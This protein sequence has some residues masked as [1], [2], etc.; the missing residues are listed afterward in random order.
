[1]LVSF[2]LLTVLGSI[3]GFVGISNINTIDE[4]ESYLYEN[5]TI[6]ISWMGEISTNFQRIRVNTRDIILAETLE[7]IEKYKNLIRDYRNS[8]DEQGKLFEERIL[9]QRMSEAWD[10]FKASRIDYG[11]DLDKLEE[12]AKENRDAEAFNLING[13]MRRTADAEMN[14]INQIMA[15]KVEDAKLERDANVESA[16]S[17]VL[18]M[19]VIIVIAFVLSI[20]LGFFISKQIASPLKQVL[21]RM[22]S[23][24]G[25]CITNLAKGTEQLANGDLNINILTGTKHLEINTKDEIGELAQNMNNVITNTQ[26]TVA[27]VDKAVKA[28]KETVNEINLIVDSAAKGDLKTRGNSSNFKGSFK[29]L[30]EGLNKTMEAVVAPIKEQS[31]VLETM[32]S[33]DLTVRMIGDYKGDF[34]IIKES[35]NNLAKSFGRA[36][37]EVTEAVQAAASASTQISSSSEEMAAGAQE[38]SAQAT[39]VAGAV[40]QMTS[41]IIQTT[42]NSSVAAESAKNAGKIAQE[43]GRVVYK[44][45]EGMNRIAE[46]VSKAAVTVQELGKSSDQIGE[47]VQVIDDIADQTNL[48]ALNAAIEA[49]RAGEQGR[50]FAVVADEVRKLAERT[51]KAT[52]EIA[53]MIKTI[54]KD[55]GDAVNSMQEGT[56]EVDMGKEL[57]NQAGESLKGIIAASDD[58]LDVISQVATASEEQSAAAEQISK[59]IES[60]S[61]VTHES[62]AGVQQIARASE[63]LN[64]LTENLQRLISQFKINESQS[65]SVSDNGKVVGMLN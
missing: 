2:L 62:A 56:E 40:E 17:A 46:V 43:G 22:Q 38:Q 7:E 51:T 29:E 5:M 61:S 21:E 3:I 19:T 58:V 57:A 23:L 26:G 36:I 53:T 48:L 59:N 14:A 4:N 32:S 54:Q 49:A 28:V 60:I 15:M 35:I 37:S 39:E 33:G 31:V 1:M 20:A 44:T 50:G 64:Q 16:S 24:S 45:V 55:T 63:D 41:T 12:L 42:K 9:S 34:L 25:L 11:R 65:Y 47:I 8:I 52:K 6:P 30:V 18:L 27:S 13:D 10:V